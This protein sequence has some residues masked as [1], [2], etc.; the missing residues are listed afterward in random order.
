MI[1]EAGEL[2]TRCTVQKRSD[3]RGDY[4]EV[5]DGWQDIGTYWGK[6]SNLTPKNVS[7][8]KGFAA[9]ISY[10]SKIRYRPEV[11]NDCRLIAYGRT[12]QIDGV[13][14]D[15]RK[16]WTQLFLTELTD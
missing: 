1:L 5:L 16:Q 6:L 15:P 3:K 9:T 10:E 13:V 4:G 12:F 8:A 11:T 14:H 7:L 2:D